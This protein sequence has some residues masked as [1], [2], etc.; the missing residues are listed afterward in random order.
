MQ[1]I[2]TCVHANGIFRRESILSI[3]NQRD[4]PAYGEFSVSRSYCK[5]PYILKWWTTA[6]DQ[7]ITE[8]IE[9]EQWYWYWGITDEIVKVT[10]SDVIKTWQQVDPL[11]SQYAWYN[12]LMYFAASRAEVL[13]LTK[14][15]RKPKW[16]TCPLCSK[17]FVENSLP[18][19]LAKRLGIDH[20]D[21]CAPCLTE[22]I[23]KG[24]DTISKEQVLSYLQDLANI[25]QRVPNQNFGEGIED[26]Q[27]LD[28]QER[29]SLLRLLRKK[30]TLQHVKELFGSWLKALVEA[31]VLEDGA[32][33]TSRGIQCLAKDEHVCF[34]LGEKTV[35][36][37][38]YSQGFAH[39]KEPH[40]P[41][42]NFRADFLIGD[43]F[44]E[45]FGLRGN[46]DYDTITRKKQRI[47]NKYGIKLISVYPS[48]LM[49]L[50]RL[51]SKL[52]DGLKRAPARC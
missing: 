9:K 51:S 1:S 47:C 2:R 5:N 13:G 48:D 23:F 7:L 24:S 18:G 31:G 25:L 8:Q 10:P 44:I 16:K 26:L 43:V 22:A 29:L 52:L 12:V 35:D 50:K 6:H 17:R 30:P 11:C 21:F 14:E 32:R 19:P 40:Y 42:G 27:G 36:D 49:S 4:K 3:Y 41:E 46:P 38:F 15:I 28:Y 34:S 20:L 45:Y 37:F 39:E 33:P